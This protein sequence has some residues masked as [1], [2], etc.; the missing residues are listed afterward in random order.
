[1]P[2]HVWYTRKYRMMLKPGMRRS[3]MIILIVVNRVP[4]LT[5]SRNPVEQA[6]YAFVSALHT[7]NNN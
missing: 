7:V 5:K 3:I 4:P 6:C 1:M 2:N